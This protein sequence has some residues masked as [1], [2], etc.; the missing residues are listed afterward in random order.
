MTTA[1]VLIVSCT[2]GLI[3]CGSALAQ[4]TPLNGDRARSVAELLER[5]EEARLREQLE[6]EGKVAE[7]RELDESIARRAEAR[8]HAVAAQL[9]AQIGVA[10]PRA[11]GFQFD[12]C[13]AMAQIR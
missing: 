11:A 13:E 6:R 8:R 2:A 3:A 10:R 12:T 5:R 9:N 4:G 7:L 1:S